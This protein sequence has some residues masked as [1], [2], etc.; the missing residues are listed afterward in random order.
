MYSAF[1]AKGEDLKLAA[2]GLQNRTVLA[3][4][5]GENEMQKRVVGVF[6]FLLFQLFVLPSAANQEPPVFVFGGKQFYVGMSE[7]EALASF[8][9][10][11]ELSPPA[12]TGVEKRPAPEGLMLGHR[13]LAREGSP[14]SILGVVY[15]SGGTIVRMTRSLDDRVDTWNDDVVAFARAINRA[16]SPTMGDRDTTVRVSIRHER[17]SNAESDVLSLSFANG[18]GIQIHIGTLDRPDAHSNK[19]DFATLD[20]TLEPAKPN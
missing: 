5:A 6:G 17:M 2:S 4:Q 16:L 19:R 9:V 11:C 15:F 1:N 20:E 14:Q 10:C 18:R 3:V 7:R 8:S 12:Q 13:I